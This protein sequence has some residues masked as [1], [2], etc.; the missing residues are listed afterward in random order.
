MIISP[1]IIWI[2]MLAVFIYT[3]G[4][5]KELW[6]EKDKSGAVVVTLIA[7]GVIVTPFFSILR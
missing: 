4:F 7:L 1:I 2:G 3:M 5:A 6:K